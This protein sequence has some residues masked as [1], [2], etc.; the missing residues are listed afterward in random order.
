MWHDMCIISSHIVPRSHIERDFLLYLQE[1]LDSQK[2]AVESAELCELQFSEVSSWIEDLN[3]QISQAKS[4]ESVMRDLC[5]NSRDITKQGMLMY[6]R[7]VVTT[8]EMTVVI[9]SPICI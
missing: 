3:E 5:N 1:V 8:Y 2:E 6:I 4:D 7:I 9:F